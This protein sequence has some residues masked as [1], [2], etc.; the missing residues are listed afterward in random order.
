LLIDLLA[1]FFNACFL[2]KMRLKAAFSVSTTRGV[3]RTRPVAERRVL[4]GFASFVQTTAVTSK[5][6]RGSQR[7]LLSTPKIADVGIW[8]HTKGTH[9]TSFPQLKRWFGSK[10]MSK[11]LLW[12]V[13]EL[14]LSGGFTRFSMTCPTG[15]T[16]T[17]RNKAI[18]HFP[19][20]WVD[21]D[22]P[23]KAV[24]HG[25]FI[26]RSPTDSSID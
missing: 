18:H 8:V 15:K 5:R 22:P 10:A 6:R 14:I 2:E 16:S 9:V 20:K 19:D 11:Y 25:R 12:I 7:L 23:P 3:T 17:V 1:P 26:A 24:G 21:P 4:W 13:K